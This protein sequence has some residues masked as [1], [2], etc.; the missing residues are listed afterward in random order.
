M[1]GRSFGFGKAGAVTVADGSG[2]LVAALRQ[3]HAQLLQ[4]AAAGF[5]WAT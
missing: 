3:R 2:E 1:V 4:V 5:R